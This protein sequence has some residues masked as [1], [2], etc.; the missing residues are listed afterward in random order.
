[1]VANMPAV[2]R[3]SMNPINTSTSPDKQNINELTGKDESSF[4][5]HEEEQQEQ[6]RSKQEVQAEIDMYE[7]RLI[8][9]EAQVEK[10]VA[11]EDY[12]LAEDYQLDIDAIKNE[13]LEKLRN[14]LKEA[15]DDI[16]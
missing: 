16:D 6:K 13:F 3:S 9:L 8:H 2:E 4:Q 1:M 5:D 7:K 11:V 14:E 10:A 12:D 15:S